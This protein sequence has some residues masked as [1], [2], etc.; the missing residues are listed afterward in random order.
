MGLSRTKYTCKDAS[1][2]YKQQIQIICVPFNLIL[3]YA[4]IS[5]WSFED[6][7]HKVGGVKFIKFKSI[8]MGQR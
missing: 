2:S 8:L 3:F 4:F 6:V 7:F 1:V 5:G